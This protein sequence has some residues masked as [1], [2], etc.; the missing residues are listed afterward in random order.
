ME[1]NEGLEEIVIQ[2]EEYN[3]GIFRFL[4]YTSR[5]AFERDFGFWDVSAEEAA[6]QPQ[7]ETETTLDPAVPYTYYIGTYYSYRSYRVNKFVMA[8]QYNSTLNTFPCWLWG[9][10]T[11]EKM[12]LSPKDRAL[13]AARLPKSVASVFFEGTA[14]V[15]GRHLYVNLAAPAADGVPAMEMHLIGFCDET[16]GQ[17]LADQDTIP[18]SLQTVSLDQ[19]TVS[20][21]AYLLRCTEEE[22]MR[23]KEDPKEYYNQD[24]QA[25]SIRDDQKKS[26]QLYLM[27]QVP[28]YDRSGSAEVP[29]QS[30]EK[31]H[32]AFD[33]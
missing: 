4:G 23:V 25:E 7:A 9:F 30:V 28:T 29:G 2:G 32:R 6:A 15:H 8:C 11:R 20:V 1:Q 24:I 26:L 12:A 31:I 10:H 22:A 21:E 18:C 27:L 5:L 16:G 19:Y 13:A 3:D 33:G 17:N 14:E